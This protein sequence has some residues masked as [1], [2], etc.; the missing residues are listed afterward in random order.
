MFTK[1]L[2][3]AAVCAAHAAAQVDLTFTSNGNFKLKHAAFLNLGQFEDSEDF[4]LVSSFGAFS[5]GHVYMVPGITDAVV[6]GDVSTLNEVK[7]DTPTFQWP[8][9]IEVVP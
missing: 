7:L 4:M 1:A 2:I 8:N 9:N 3:S 6:A 5:S